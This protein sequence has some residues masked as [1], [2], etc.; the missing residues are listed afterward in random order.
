MPKC[1]EFNGI[2]IL[3]TSQLYLHVATVLIQNVC[4][5]A[6]TGLI[7]SNSILKTD[8]Q[9]CSSHMILKAGQQIQGSICWQ[10]SRRNSILMTTS[11]YR[12]VLGKLIVAHLF[13]TFCV[14]Y[15]V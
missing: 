6:G 1:C 5:M 2:N 9:Y 8:P 7:S 15:K 11:C 3:P 4:G 10:I 14:L 13:K 12:V